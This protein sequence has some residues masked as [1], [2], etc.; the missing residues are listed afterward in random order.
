MPTILPADLQDRARRN[1][2]GAMG[3]DPT[4][5]IQPVY[6]TDV[7]P[8]SAT[9]APAAQ[10]APVTPPA[11]APVPQ[12]EVIAAP[13][14]QTAAAAPPPAAQV[15]PRP[16]Q[17]APSPPQQASASGPGAIPN[18]DHSPREGEKP[19]E[20]VLRLANDVRVL[21]YAIA[22]M[23][24]QLTEAI[25][26]SLKE[27][28]ARS[29]AEAELATAG[30][31]DS[32]ELQA[33]RQQL[34]QVIAQTEQLRQT[35]VGAHRQ[36]EQW[37]E[38]ARQTEVRL[39]TSMQAAQQHIKGLTEQAAA[40]EAA[41]NQLRQTAADQ[42]AE[43][44]SARAALGTAHQRIAE[45]EAQLVRGQARHPRGNIAAMAVPAAP[46]TPAPQPPAP[47]PVQAPPAPKPA[48]LPAPVYDENPG[49]L[50]T[51]IDLAEWQHDA[52][53]A[54]AAAGHKG[55]VESVTSDGNVRLAYWAIGRALD[56]GMKALVLTPSPERVDRWHEGLVAA[57]PTTRVGKHSGRGNNQLA[58]YDVV[59]SS[60]QSAI[61]ERVFEPGLGV[62]VVAD[63]VQEFG[64][65]KLIRA[66]DPSYPWR[67]GL[68]S[69]YE[70]DD[71]GVATYLSRYFGR[72]SFS[73]GYD[74]AL[75]EQAVASFDLAM[76]SVVF[77]SSEQGEYDACA[78]A[79]LAGGGAGAGAAKAAV[80][81]YLKAVARRDE[82]LAGT[83]ARDYTLRALATAV[84]DSGRA[85]VVAP[86]PQVADYVAR[87]LEDRGCAATPIRTAVNGEARIRRLGK[88]E[89]DRDSWLL[90]GPR[91]SNPAEA[92]SPIDL[93]I[94]VSPPRSRQQLIERLDRVLG[95]RTTNRHVRIAV[96]YVED[97]IEDDTADEDAAAIAEVIP[98]AR[99]LQRLSGRDDDK[100]LEFLA[101]GRRVVTLP[102]D[103]AVERALRSDAGVTE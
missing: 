24:K 10:P 42:R 72:V 99:R 61:N 39:K 21:T 87:V 98:Y 77:S 48:T 25:E 27:A 73:L 4:A 34:Q 65:A 58:A 89:E 28:N 67:L 47:P 44:D 100:L 69:S 41:A 62:L 81:S 97:S 56:A 1:R 60:A 19:T 37:S 95:G 32:A 79:T 15:A 84:R 93:A 26:T 5:A 22:Y 12:A 30:G 43:L 16:Q 52:L 35:V 51:G 8:Q 13:P 91:G 38:H 75:A 2:A 11:P 92:S 71:D 57:L 74:R 54:W 45:L 78:A 17:A 80:R 6:P 14:A 59:V 90:V 49:T 76:I 31:P 36:A 85:L 18:P 9:P 103:P 64:T 66:L 55:V 96:L 82:I 86:T 70:R 101:A 88:T 83:T 68:T 94:M 63:D 29:A 7:A 53:A 40:H 20:H 102:A 33:A 3:G 50:T 23:R 46:G